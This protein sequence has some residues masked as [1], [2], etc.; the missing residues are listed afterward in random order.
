MMQ[1]YVCASLI[2]CVTGELSM[3]GLGNISVC[4]LTYIHYIHK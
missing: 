1:E 2:T 4:K 3:E